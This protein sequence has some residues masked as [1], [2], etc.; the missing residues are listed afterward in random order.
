MYSCLY[1]ICVDIH[2]SLSLCLQGWVF[3]HFKSL[4][5]RKVEED[6]E[7]ADPL[8]GKWKPLRGFTNHG[9][10]NPFF[11]RIILI[12]YYI[13]LY[14]FMCDYLSLCVFNSD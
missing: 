9:C 2:L 1:D 14:V 7:R 4:L 13:C 6:Y 12:I 11:A 5:P 10:N 3:A 8:V